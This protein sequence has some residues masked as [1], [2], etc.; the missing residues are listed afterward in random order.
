MRITG[1]T[2]EAFNIGL[3]AVSLVL[4]VLATALD[5]WVSA[6]APSGHIVFEKGLWKVCGTIFEKWL[7]VHYSV[8]EGKKPLIFFSTTTIKNR[9]VL[10][11]L[12]QKLKLIAIV[13][14]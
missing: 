8:V 9:L 2:F 14:V 7:C 11:V 4:T 13:I 12:M 3:A 10:L 1:N 5:T 6:I